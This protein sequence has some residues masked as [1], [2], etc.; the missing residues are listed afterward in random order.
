MSREKIVQQ[1]L[2]L[3]PNGNECIVSPV[4]TRR[5]NSALWQVPDPSVQ[6]RAGGA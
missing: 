1:L 2:Q 6:R 5:L 4:T 3:K